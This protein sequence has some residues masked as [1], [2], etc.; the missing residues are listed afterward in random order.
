MSLPLKYGKMRGTLV[1]LKRFL[2][3]KIEGEFKCAR[4]S[5]FMFCGLCGL[6]L[7]HYKFHV[8]LFFLS[9]ARGQEVKI[10]K[11]DDDR[12]LLTFNCMLIL[13]AVI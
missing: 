2:L 13:L 1:Y 10:H 5:L 12:L 11:D 4:M 6:S 8:G 7:V 9:P 3:K